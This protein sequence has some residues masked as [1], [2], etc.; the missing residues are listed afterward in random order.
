MKNR[1]LVA[2]ASLVAACLL[3][4]P[5]IAR[6]VEITVMSSGAVK[7]AYLEPV[8][9]FEQASQNKVVTL[10]TGTADMMK[11]LKAGEQVD[12][13][14]VGSDSLDELMRLGKVEPGSRVDFVK[15]GVGVAVRAG[16]PKPDISSGDALKRTL[17]AA[18]SIGYSS[19]PS[20]VYLEG[21]FQRMGITE[22]LRPKLR[23]TPSGVPVGEILA[24]GEVEIGFQQ[25][26]ELIHVRGIDFVGAL[27]SD[28]Q[29]VTIFSTG[30]HT[31]AT[32][33]EAA[34]AWVRFLTSPAAVPVIRKN[35]L[36]PG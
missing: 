13:V 27:P 8:P 31:G 21:L 29:Q 24:K 36:E 26:S 1:W 28:I 20:G 30:I 14:I 11:R 12:L 15:S 22:Q 9:Q 6:S 7:E 5:E 10:W 16:A 34:K 19:G 25:V 32:Q 33:R 18:T 17:L 4:L 3:V 35:G 2:V 23:Q